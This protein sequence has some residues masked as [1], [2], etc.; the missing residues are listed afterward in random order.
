MDKAIVSRAKFVVQFSS[1]EGA[2]VSSRTGATLEQQRFETR[3]SMN[4]Q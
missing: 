2:G 4:P 3:N 1:A